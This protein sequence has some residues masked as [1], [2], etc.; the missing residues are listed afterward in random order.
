MPLLLHHNFT[1]YVHRVSSFSTNIIY[2]DIE[3][4]ILSVMDKITYYLL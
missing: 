1:N 3:I 2:L 4:F